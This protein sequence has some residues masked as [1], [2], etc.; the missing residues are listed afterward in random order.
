MSRT[1]WDEPKLKLLDNINESIECYYCNIETN[2]KV[3]SSAQFSA[4]FFTDDE[5]D[6]SIHATTSIEIIQCQGCMSPSTR[7]SS[8]DSEAVDY[9]SDG[10]DPIISYDFYPKRNQLIAFDNAYQLPSALEDLYL[11]TVNAINNGSLIIAGIGIRGLIETVCREENIEGK[12]LEQKIN[13]LF[14]AGKIS[15]DSKD[16]LHSLRMIYNKSAHESFKPSKEQLYISLEIVELLLKQLY[17]HSHLAKKHFPG[18][19]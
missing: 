5:H 4:S 16:I 10:L 11:E 17:I 12:N 13:S 9:H 8:W 2:H 7:F 19:K 15:K 3:L 14:A 6:N 18:N 1:V